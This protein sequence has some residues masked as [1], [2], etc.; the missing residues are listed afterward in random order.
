M[1]TVSC[2]DNTCRDAFSVVADMGFALSTHVE[3]HFVPE[4]ACVGFVNT[5]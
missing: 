2:M 1:G 5:C 4:L 3:M